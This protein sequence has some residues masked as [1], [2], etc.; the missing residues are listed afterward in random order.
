[1][2]SGLIVIIAFTTTWLPYFVAVVW[3]T[4]EPDGWF[5]FVYCFLYASVILNPLIYGMRSM[6]FNGKTIGD[7]VRDLCGE[8]RARARALSQPVPAPA[9]NVGVENSAYS[10]YQDLEDDVEDM[11]TVY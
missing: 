1:M 2:Y 3:Q 5:T 8:C 6:Q 11:N 7:I 9:P 10:S 4:I